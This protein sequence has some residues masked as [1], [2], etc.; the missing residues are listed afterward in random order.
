MKTIKSTKYAN[1]FEGYDPYSVNFTEEED[2]A[3]GKSTDEL[4]N[5]LK[6]AIETSQVSPNAGKY[7]DQAS[8]YRR[9]LESRGIGFAQQDRLI[10]QRPSLHSNPQTMACTI[11]HK[12]AQLDIVECSVCGKSKNRD[13]FANGEVCL[14]CEDQRQI[15]N[16]Q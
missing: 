4:L 9:E 6:D 10:S 15:G 14:D 1:T 8:V 3:K 16:G 12:K 5:A 13:Q 7:T 11:T 2:K